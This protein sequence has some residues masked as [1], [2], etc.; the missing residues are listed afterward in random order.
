MNASVYDAIA[1]ALAFPGPSFEKELRRIVS[2]LEDAC[3][4]AAERLEK[5]ER[6]LPKGDVI[7]QQELHTRTFDVQPITSL[8]IGYTLFGEDYKRGAVLAN[9]ANEHVRAGND[10]G[11]EL[12]DHLTNVLRLLPKLTD[13]ELRGELVE[14]LVGPAL[15][16]MIR[17]FETGRLTKKEEIYRK[18]HKTVLEAADGDR[19]TAYRFV[20]EAVLEVLRRDFS[21]GRGL[22]LHDDSKFAASVGAELTIENSGPHAAK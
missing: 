14:V 19:R 13:D 22:P 18:H 7:A 8:D 17:E 1:A 16:E 20:L 4:E 11:M 9:L 12:G 3:P 15:R 6:L 5:F 2:L 21:V 10:C